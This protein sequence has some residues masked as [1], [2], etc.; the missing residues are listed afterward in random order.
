MDSVPICIL[1]LIKTEQINIDIKI[2]TVTY[3]VK[4]IP[5]ALHFENLH[6]INPG[7]IFD[8]TP[9]LCVT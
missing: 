7:F 5:D 2:K 1:P 4:Q 6:N 8:H 3:T 9:L